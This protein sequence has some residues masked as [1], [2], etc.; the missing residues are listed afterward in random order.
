MSPQGSNVDVSIEN[1]PLPHW[2]TS[3]LA[4]KHNVMSG[5]QKMIM[6]IRYTFVFTT[7]YLPTI[8]NL[9][10]NATHRWHYLYLETR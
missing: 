1:Q 10:S 5:R 6:C 8:T 4:S 9:V 3:A 7:L 2:P